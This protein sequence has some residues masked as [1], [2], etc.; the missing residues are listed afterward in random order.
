MGVEAGGGRARGPRDILA[1]LAAEE[2]RGL[3]GL[4]F[5][6]YAPAADPQPEAL[7]LG[8]SRV[9]GMVTEVVL[10]HGSW[11][12]AEGPYVAVQTL[13]SAGGAD[14]GGLFDLREVVEDERDRIF[15]RIG[16]D[17]GEA[18]DL[19]VESEIWIAVDGTPVRAALRSE[20][21]LWAARLTLGGAGG[22][23]GSGARGDAVAAGREPVT[24]TVT[25]RGLP[26]ERVRL[27]TVDQLE[28]YALGQQRQLAQL[29]VRRGDRP[30]VRDRELPPVQGLEGH[31]E[32]I[33]RGV[34]DA[35]RTEAALRAGRAPRQP[36]SEPRDRGELWERT[37]RQQMR[38]AGEDHQTA[39]EAVTALVNQMIG[40]AEGAD[41]FPD[42]DAAGAAVEESIRFTVFDSEVSSIEAQRAWQAYWFTRMRET[43]SVEDGPVVRRERLHRH[44]GV[45]SE[46]LA[47]WQQWY[48]DRL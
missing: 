44:L 46:W 40:L 10:A 8:W 1:E 43:G 15:A 38:L 28:P 34:R 39:N 6:V 36:R 48:N 45:R 18:P 19:V 7:A 23:P 24:V 31:R 30:H 13:A 41:W 35:L 25:G 11:F 17:E 5:R 21:R 47:L 2:L 37:V 14:H 27:R 9:N 42:S 29:R 26:P 22:G 16:L 33:G 32:L 12:S 4:A 20:G 3:D